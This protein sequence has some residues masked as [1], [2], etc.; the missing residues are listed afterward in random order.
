MTKSDRGYMRQALD[1][2]KDGQFV[3]AGD[4]YTVAAYESLARGLPGK[5]GIKISGGEVHLLRAAICYRV[6]DRMD[7]SR[8]RCRQ[9]ILIAEDMIDRVFDMVPPT[10][11]YDRARR[12]VWYEYIGDFRC[13]GDLRDPAAAYEKAIEVYEAADDPD[14]MY[15]EQEH[16]YTMAVYREVA[17][18]VDRDPG[19]IDDMCNELTLSDWVEQKR[20]TYPSLLMEATDSERF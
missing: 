14:T 1:L 13:I 11:F 17:K 18:A 7:R 15:S 6:G 20:E 9:G 10:N 5:Y 12:G 3:D 2:R 16:S 8:N 19:P 4:H